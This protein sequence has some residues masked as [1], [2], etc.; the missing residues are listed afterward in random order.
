MID[1]TATLRGLTTGTGTDYVW[2]GEPAGLLGTA[3]VRDADEA[4]PR[5]DG[6][7]GSD[8]FLGGRRVT[9]EIVINKLTRVDGEV[10]AAA[11]SASFAPSA[12]DEWLDVRVTGSPAEY[13]LRGRPRGVVVVAD[14]RFVGGAVAAR[15]TFVATDPVRYGP[16]SSVLISLVSPGSG[17]MYPVTYPVVYSGGGSGSGT[18]PALNAGTT[19]VDWSATLTGPLTNPRL[20]LDGSGRFVRVLATVAAGETV[21]LDSATSSILLNGLA[22]RPSWFAPGSRWFR[23]AAGSNSLTFTADAGSGT[24]LVKWRS[25]WS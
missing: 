1:G 13:S 12:V 15:C 2:V 14:E 8:D 23:L 9:F 25:G 22:P 20:A 11:L 21:V 24:C 7:I 10:A 5:R 4:F 17:L 19:D 18:A 6:L 16:E 3:D